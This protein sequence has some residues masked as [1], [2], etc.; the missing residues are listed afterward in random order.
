MVPL[1]LVTGA[2]GL[3]GRHIMRSLEKVPSIRL[4]GVVRGDVAGLGWSNVKADMASDAA[5]DELVRLSPAII[6]HAAAVLP[7]SFDDE[8]AALAN[9]SIDKNVVRI[10]ETSGAGVIFLS[11]SSVYANAPLPWTEDLQLGPLPAYAALKLDTETELRRLGRYAALRISSPYSAVDDTRRSVLYNF[12]RQAVAKQPLRVSDI[13]RTQ[14][15]IHAQDIGNAVRL[16]LLHMLSGKSPALPGVY[17]IVSAAPISM[18]GLAEKIVGL[19]GSGQVIPVQSS[20]GRV[21]YRAVLSREKARLDLK[22]EPEVAIETGIAQLIRRMRGGHED[23]LV[24]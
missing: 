10:A 14:D 13:H 15:F 8:A 6:V 4:L 17:N 24:I 21:P 18:L 7:S 11:S 12:V 19:C 23:W 22:W 2:G 5:Y 16:A 20:D 3:V 9:A 1:V